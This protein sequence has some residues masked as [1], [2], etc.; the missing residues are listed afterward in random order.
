MLQYLTFRR[1]LLVVTVQ[2]ATMLFGM[3][4]TV[5]S[6]LMP[7]LKGA[8][9]ATQDQIAWT[10][11]FNLVAT[12]IAIPLTGWLAT[13]LGWRNLLVGSIGCFTLATVFFVGFRP[14]WKCWCSSVFCKVFLARR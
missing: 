1:L 7:Q 11:T 9:S 14:R 10:I 6:V 4:V 8:L 12:A 13:R 3:T 5:V 2:L